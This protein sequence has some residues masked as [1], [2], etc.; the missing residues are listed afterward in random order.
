VPQTSG[1]PSLGLPEWTSDGTTSIDNED[2]VLWHTFGLTHFPAPEDF[3]VMPAEPMGLLLR[4]RNF[5][6]RNPALDVPPSY[7]STPSQVAA[8]KKGVVDGTDKQ[9][10]LAFGGFACNGCCDKEGA[11]E[12]PR[13]GP[14]VHK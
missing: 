9:S 4:P 8:G 6:L 10:K 1:N 12:G 7:A 5:F 11:G 13:P 14:F 3:P 2:I